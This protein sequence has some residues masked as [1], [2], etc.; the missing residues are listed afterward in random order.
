MTRDEELLLEAVLSAHRARGAEGAL[1][2]ASEYF[3][4]S[5]ELRTEAFDAAVV[6][7][8]LEAALDPE[9]LSSTARAVLARIRRG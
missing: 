2:P 5:P 8:N 3:D 1:R 9:G 7:R 4:L 6:L